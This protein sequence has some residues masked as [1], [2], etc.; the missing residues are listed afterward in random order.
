MPIRGVRIVPGCISC[1][2]CEEH[3]PE[4][5][6]V[7]GTSQVR[8]GVDPND[9]EGGVRLAAEVCPVA[10]IQVDLPEGAA[11]EAAAVGAGKAS[12]A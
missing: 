12:K 9:F 4:V 1:C 11:P 3:C 6:L 8:P 10:V 2:A 7:V 5:F